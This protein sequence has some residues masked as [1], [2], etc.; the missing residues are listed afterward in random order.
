MLD[1]DENFT[2]AWIPTLGP[3]SK[4]RHLIP[5]SGPSGSS[6]SSKT[7]GRD[8]EERWSLDRAPDIGCSSGQDMEEI[9]TLKRVPDVGS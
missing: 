9:R 6:M 3:S 2:K 1:L 8:L 5:T 4:K 7:P